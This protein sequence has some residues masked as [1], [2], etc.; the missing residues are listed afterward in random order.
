MV[1][2]SLTFCLAGA[3]LSGGQVVKSLPDAPA[4]QYPDQNGNGGETTPDSQSTAEPGI[5]P[6]DSLSDR[7][8]DVPRRI[9][10][11]S[12]VPPEKELHSLN[13]DE[14]LQV[15]LK[16]TYFGAGAYFERALGA[17]YDQARGV[18]SAWGGGM[19]GFTRRFASR[20]GQFVIRNTLKSAG[21]AALGYEPRYDLCRCDGFWNRTKHAIMRNLLTYNSTERELRPQLPYYGAAFVAG[22]AATT[23]KP[24]QHNVW[25]DGGIALAEQMGWGALRNWLSEFSGDI[26]KKLSRRH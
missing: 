22:M 18:P 4:P 11:G 16:Q 9:L 10:L 8:R 20:Y 13:R 2:V 3:A 17:G 21:D 1:A 15:Y 5:Y 19:E 23:W 6:Q 14:R 26:G 7:L 24:G 12:A 25:A